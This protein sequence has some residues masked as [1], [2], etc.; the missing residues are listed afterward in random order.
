MGGIDQNDFEQIFNTWYEPIRNFLYY[1][2]CDIKTSE[3]LA[4][5]V[6]MKVWEKRNTIR[7]ETIKPF[8][9][10]LANNLFLN[11]Q[12]HLKVQ[13][14]FAV[15]YQ[16]ALLHDG[17]DVDL[18]AKEFDKKLQDAINELDDKKRTVFLMNRIEKLTYNQIAEC[19]GITV[20]AVEKRM[21]KALACLKEQIET[22][23]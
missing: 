23:I 11:R 21:E 19:L 9:Y 18:E 1:K 13:L 2:T 7:P 17:P 8:L 3:D 16:P 15:S 14:K 4:Q 5:D 12:E 10:T 20:K 22:N 6:F